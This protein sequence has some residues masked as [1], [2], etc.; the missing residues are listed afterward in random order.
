[1]V[2][3][4]LAEPLLVTD[5]IKNVVTAVLI[6]PIEAFLTQSP[7]WLIIA[8]V[9]GVALLLSGRRPGDPRRGLARR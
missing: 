9:V 1:M 6:N 7:W 2:E 8:L 5:A 4:G 3:V